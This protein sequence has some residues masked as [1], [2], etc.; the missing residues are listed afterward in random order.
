MKKTNAARMLDAK[1]F[2][3]ELVNTTWMK[4]IFTRYFKL[5]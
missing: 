2:S 1:S 5:N 3:Y 4:P